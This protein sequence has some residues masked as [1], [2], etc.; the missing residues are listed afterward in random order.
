MSEVKK[1]SYF[2]IFYK[3]GGIEFEYSTPYVSEAY[4]AIKAI[5]T[6]E[7]SVAFPNKGEAFC[8][9]FVVLSDIASG[10]TLNHENHIF[11]IE[12]K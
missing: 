11:R 2:R 8:N 4:E 10:K 6:R 5:I 1:A 12:G 9:Y 7:S 3:V